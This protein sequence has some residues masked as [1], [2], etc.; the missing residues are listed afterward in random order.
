MLCA[1]IPF[2]VTGIVSLVVWHTIKKYFVYL[3]YLIKIVFCILYFEPG[4]KY[5][6][7]VFQVQI[8]KVFLYFVFEILLKSILHNT[9]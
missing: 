5:L 6:R 1:L 2:H 3:K 7:K 8:F 4:Q 9:G